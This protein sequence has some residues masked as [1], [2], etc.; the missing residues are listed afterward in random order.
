[1]TVDIDLVAGRKWY[2]WR[3]ERRCLFYSGNFRQKQAANVI[4]RAAD[5]LNDPHGNRNG[6]RCQQLYAD[7]KERIEEMQRRQEQLREQNPESTGSFLDTG[8]GMPLLLPEN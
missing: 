3:Q 2:A 1:M 5:F 6:F 7:A 4:G 8:G